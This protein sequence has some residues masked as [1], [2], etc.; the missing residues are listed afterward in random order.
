[1]WD[2]IVKSPKWTYDYLFV[3]FKGLHIDLKDSELKVN[4]IEPSDE[5]LLCIEVDEYGTVHDYAICKSSEINVAKYM[6]HKGEVKCNFINLNGRG[7][8]AINEFQE[9]FLIKPWISI[10]REP[11]PN[12]TKYKLLLRKQEHLRKDSSRTDY[13]NDNKENIVYIDDV[14]AP[15]FTYY[16]NEARMK[17]NLAYNVYFSDFIKL[18]IKAE[19]IMNIKLSYKVGSPEFDA[20]ESIER[21][22]YEEMEHEWKRTPMRLFKRYYDSCVF[23]NVETGEDTLTCNTSEIVK[24]MQKKQRER[25]RMLNIEITT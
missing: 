19:K 16:W 11:K 14:E 13:G 18:R 15:L 20:V 8:T 23:R 17:K 3:S 6:N 2:N 4:N 12:V 5:M 7:F 1:M 10:V 22:I 9:E 24:Y 21:V 25:A